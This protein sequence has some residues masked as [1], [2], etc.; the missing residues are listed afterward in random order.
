MATWR[1]WKHIITGNHLLGWNNKP[2]S[3]PGSRAAKRSTMLT[4]W[5]VWCLAGR[6]QFGGVFTEKA[7]YESSVSEPKQ[8]RWPVMSWKMLKKSSV[9]LKIAAETGDT[10]YY[11]RLIFIVWQ[12]KLK[13][14]ITVTLLW[15]QDSTTLYLIPCQDFEGGHDLVGGVG[16]GRL[17]GH[18]VDEGLEGDDAHP[19]GIHYA[20][21]AGELILTLV[22]RKKNYESQ[23]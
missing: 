21:N 22:A 19:V 11:E 2:V 10:S 1:Q 18:E 20:H 23:T 12:W 8:E 17:A 13:L 4:S 15:W 3:T 9:D 7:A 6:V 14:C 5:S 16:V